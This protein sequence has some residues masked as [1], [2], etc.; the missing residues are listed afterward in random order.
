MKVWEAFK[1][2]LTLANQEVQV[3]DPSWKNLAAAAK[4]RHVDEDKC[5]SSQKLHNNLLR[6]QI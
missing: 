5:K 6:N 4:R 1:K 2:Q 3:I